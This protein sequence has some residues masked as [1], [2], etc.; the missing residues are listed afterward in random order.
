MQS[1][2]HHGFAAEPGCLIL[3]SPKRIM[4]FCILL[5]ALLIAIPAASADMG[6]GACGITV[7]DAEYEHLKAF[8]IDLHQNP[9]LSGLEVNTSRKVA[10]ELADAGLAVTGHVGGYGVVGVLRNGDGPVVGIRG[11]MDALPITEKTGLPYAS[12]VVTT[13]QNR[14]DTGVMHACGHDS[15]STVIVGTARYLAANRGCWNGT[16]VVIAQ[17]AEETSSGA[18]AMIAD[19]LF[20]RFPKPDYIVGI[21]SASIP[22]GTIMYGKGPFMSGKS[23][24]E[25]TIR[26]YGG[27]GGNPQKTIDPVVTAAYAIVSLQTLVS[28]ENSPTNPISITVGAVNGGTRENIIPEEVRL[29]VDIRAGTEEQHT[30]LTGDVKRVIDSVARAHGVPDELMPVYSEPVFTP[31]VNADPALADRI[32]QALG[33]GI[34]PENVTVIPARLTVSEDF[35]FYGMTPEKIPTGFIFFGGPPRSADPGVPEMFRVP[36]SHNPRYA[37]DPEPTLKTAVR[38][39]SCITLDLFGTPAPPD[40]EN[41]SQLTGVQ[42]S[43]T[44]PATTPLP[45]TM[46]LAGTGI[47]S[48]IVIRKCKK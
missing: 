43:A 41:S 48:L 10:Q 14:T 17:P 35:S 13:Y 47:A 31:P 12:T 8:Y 23:A 24:M 46:A 27:H 40:Q 16:L 37:V 9:E 22:A 32:G 11:D 3:P 15:H 42:D 44:G 20:T 7:S 4:I 21:H 5:N 36:S 26:G 2:Y 34:G 18:K 33:A 30:K 19:G 29:N 6:T 1:R 45:V 39:L 25:V 38:A 28:R